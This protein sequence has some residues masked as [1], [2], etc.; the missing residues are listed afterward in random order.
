MAPGRVG[1][2]CKVG[3]L[4]HAS[5]SLSRSGCDVDSL[6]VAWVS[7]FPGRYK[8]GLI[9]DALYFIRLERL[10]VSYHMLLR[11]GDA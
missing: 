3:R 1:I 4:D 9:F 11:V 2:P 7:S 5:L 8:S 10:T 6:F